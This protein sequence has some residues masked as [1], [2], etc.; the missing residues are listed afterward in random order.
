MQIVKD[1]GPWV[2]EANLPVPNSGF[3][4]QARPFAHFK[5]DQRQRTVTLT[6]AGMEQTVRFLG[7][8]LL[9]LRLLAQW[10]HCHG[11]LA[12]WHSEHTLISPPFRWCGTICAIAQWICSCLVV[13]TF[14]RTHSLCAYLH[15]TLSMAQNS[16]CDV[17]KGTAVSSP[18]F[19]EETGLKRSGITHLL[20]HASFASIARRLHH[21]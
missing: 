17:C 8:G 11:G 7:T 5:S 4:G 1:M 21:I 16:I 9:F 15:S 12:W 2:D 19:F 14:E 3:W 10:L 20:V 13:A 6:R 18:P